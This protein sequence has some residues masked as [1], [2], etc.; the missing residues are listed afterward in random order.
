[1]LFKQDRFTTCFKTCGT[2][3]CFF[4]KVLKRDNS[5]RVK[6]ANIKRTFKI[7][8]YVDFWREK[9]VH[10]DANVQNEC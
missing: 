4:R 6:K 7:N 10:F 3:P 2:N 1:M 9:N 8:V 5:Q